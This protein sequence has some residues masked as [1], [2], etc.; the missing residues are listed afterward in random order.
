MR[1]Q[2]PEPKPFYAA[3]SEARVL[4]GAERIEQTIALKLRVLQGK[5]GAFVLGLKG[6]GEVTEVSG[7]H[8]DSWAVRRE[9]EDRFLE[10]RMAAGSWKD[11]KEATFSPLIK[12]VAR[13]IVL[14][15]SFELA[16]L[17]RGKSVGFESMIS[18]EYEPGVAASV[19]RAEGF[20]PVDA[21]GPPH[22]F[23]SSTGGRLRLALARSGAA[24]GPV[25]LRRVKLSGTLDEGERSASFSLR[26][27]ARV[28]E[29]GAALT[30]LR[31]N[32]AESA[33]PADAP[34]R[35]ELEAV[36]GGAPVYRLVFDQVGTWPVELDFVAVVSSAAEWKSVDFT[37]G[38]GA[39]APLIL[40]G[41]GAR[42]EFREGTSVV[43]RRRAPKSAAWLGFVPASGHIALAWKNSRKVGEGNLFFSTTARVEATLGAG[44]LRQDHAIDY[45]VLQGEL[46]SL[47]IALEGPGEV[48]DV[49]GGNVVAWTVAGEEDARRLEIKLSQAITAQS[50]LHI[51]TQTPL[52]AF[53]VRVEG[54]RLIPLG[55][56]RHSGYIRLSNRGSVRLEPAGLA[57]LTQLAPEQFPGEPIEARQVFV[58]RFPAAEHAYQIAAERIEAE[59]NVSQV[60]LY[61]LAETDRAIEA[62]LELDI[63]EA[64]VREWNLRLPASYSVVSVTGARV[65]DYVV[66]SEVEN[67]ARNLVVIFAQD[68]EGRQLVS[69]HLEKN[70]A[71][72]AGPWALPRLEFPGAKSVRG[73]IGIVGA[74]GFRIAVGETDLLVEK[75]LSYFPKPVPNLQQ[76]FRM[77]EPLWSA[78]MEVEL[79]EQ[80]VQADVFHLYSLSE[81]T[82][83]ASVLFNYFV[84]GA[85]VSEWEISLPEELGNV[86]VDGKDVRTWRRGGDTLSVSLH[87]SV[88]GSYTLLLTFEETLE[89]G[90]LELGRVSPLGVQGERGYL[91]LVS[92][93]QVKT[94]TTRI[95]EGLLELDALELPAEFRLLSSAPPLGT[96]QY[97]ERPFE[98]ALDVDWFQPGATVSQ[99]VEFAEVN[100]RVS[101]DG[102]L[103]TDIL[104]YL[105]SR[106]RQPLV[107]EL[108]EDVR[109]WAVSVGGVAVSARQSDAATL[110]P[111]PGGTDPNIPAEVRLRLG[112][113]AVDGRSPVLALPKVSVPVL[114]TEWQVRGDDKHVLVPAGGNVDPP[115]PVLPSSGFAWVV[116]NALLSLL[117]VAVFAGLGLGLTRKVGTGRFFGL[118]ALVVAV[119]IAAGTAIV[120]HA[121]AGGPMP[122]R[123]TLP[124]LIPGQEV[125][126]KLRSVPLWR[127]NLSLLGLFAALAGTVCVLRSYLAP[128]LRR[129]LY[130]AGGL[131]LLALGL[132]LQRG[133]AS[134]FFGLLALVLLVFFFVP[135][136]KQWL[137]VQRTSWRDWRAAR[138]ESKRRRATA[139]AA[140]ATA[141]IG[142]VTILS[143][144]SSGAAQ[145]RSQAP[146]AP[147]AIP[148]GFEAANE[149]RQQ[150]TISH[151]QKRLRA[152]GSIR[153]AGKPGDRYLLLRAPAVLTR[154]EGKGLRLTRQNVPGQG[155]AYVVSIPAQPDA[156]AAGYQAA[157]EFDLEIVDITKGFPLPTGPA[158]VQQI[159]ASYDRP[160]WEF[161]S[162]SAVRIDAATTAGGSAKSAA[163]ILLAPR[164]NASFSLAPKARD[165]AAEDTLF[166]VE[167]ANLY[168]P[169]PGVVD[170][171]HR[172][173]VR[174]SQGR[175][176]ALTIQVPAGL[177]VSE[178]EGPVGSWQFDADSRALQL[179]IEPAQSQAFD[180]RIDT[181]RGL[182][183]LP[184]DATL[185]PLTVAGAA[186]EVGL[187]ALAFAADAQPERADSATMSAVNLSDFHA[188]LLPGESAVLHRV[189]RYGA[190]GGEVTLR[191]APVAPEIRVASTQVL[192]LGDE[193]IVLGI[194]F[195]AEITRA[196]LF[197]L[198]FPL[199]AGLEVESL[200]GSALHHWAEL[201]EGAQR[202]I[203]LHLNGKTLGAQSFALS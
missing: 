203:V 92:P 97:T 88:I 136:A 186:G 79:L 185:A 157:F 135:R 134:W 29:P 3:T 89:G 159:V 69:L 139:A 12:I 170:G 13:D 142:T 191:I 65:A 153:L 138:R 35:L 10:L 175:V 129:D 107:L 161:V 200:S 52:G 23:R 169:G 14:P 5:P 202:Q 146:P 48:L 85:P 102:E 172:I 41:I 7:E 168:L 112:K 84:T 166:Y 96:W 82:A 118:L 144:L 123:L 109:L 133:S 181:Q 199:P 152:E 26:G 50:Q 6:E 125:E 74:P 80:S 46:E 190:E 51:R 38:A 36:G 71:A 1:G 180:V 120:A 194:N 122:L 183:P 192:S 32:A 47:E 176:E 49:E 193:R 108:P 16:H 87:Q 76:A 177:T 78:T 178:V 188:S 55:A 27:I 163:T 162:P 57:G 182:D 179:A 83:Y 164:A 56:V 113:P 44:L 158:A 67:G 94:E 39:V 114:K 25:E 189:Y 154:F 93:M 132:L 126:L 54:L 147:P 128:L 86:I 150:W 4:V 121:Q 171:R 9:G 151:Q 167:G 77:R 165:V 173:H 20:T 81:G 28:T 98:L 111:L 40:E 99:V 119:V 90:V 64:A 91:Q 155:L 11:G 141:I 31:G 75:P 63:R 95:S 104:Y 116:R 117:L 2:L 72:A 160:G 197:A 59:I 37:V 53:P 149:I 145:A 103:V 17:A 68:V 34:Y 184:T 124:G 21:E 100:S 110:I 131:L 143:I 58:Y 30:I 42:V 106:G 24:P 33:A 105:K 45:R 201:S 19:I 130:R 156:P 70:E 101:P 22:Q 137:G 195:T 174:P 187:V 43:P 15:R 115:V 148:A 196:G 61:Q 60:V 127:A 62:D 18:I 8:L 140:A 198:S 73:D 66:G